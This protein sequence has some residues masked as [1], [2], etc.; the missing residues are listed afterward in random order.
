M[1]GKRLKSNCTPS[2]NARMT[3]TSKH[4]VPA[5]N[6]TKNVGN[7]DNLDIMTRPRT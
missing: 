1:E 6:R 2:K 7:H 3:T 5:D 4:A